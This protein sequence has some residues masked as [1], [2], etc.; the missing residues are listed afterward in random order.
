MIKRVV[1]AVVVV[2]VVWSIIDY[3]VHGMILHSVYLAT[4]KLWRPMA[5]MKM[6]LMYFVGLVTAVFF[7][8]I[9]AYLIR[10]KS[11]G[12]GLK[13]GLL[14]GLAWGI[15]MGYGTYAVM[16]LPYHMALTWFLSTLFESL[17][18]G[19]LAALIVKTPEGQSV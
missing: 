18:G 11:L 13:Y 9:Y 14:F 2:F 7:V 3:I 1:L 15:S 16:P 5:D 19:F 17:V 12:M 8:C 4:A 10:P 6:G